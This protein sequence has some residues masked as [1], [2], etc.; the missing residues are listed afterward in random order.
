WGDRLPRSRPMSDLDVLIQFERGRL[1]ALVAA[2]VKRASP[3]H[4][5]DFQLVTPRGIALSRE[6]YLGEIRDGGINYL[7]W[8]PVEI[9]GRI[10]GNTGVLRYRSRM[11]MES[12]GRRLTDIQCWHTD[13]YERA[14]GRWQVIY[15]Q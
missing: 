15:S 13:Y 14:D 12:H 2:D 4:H 11:E 8:E 7:V 1:A 6:A 9:D 3:M 5:P 10:A